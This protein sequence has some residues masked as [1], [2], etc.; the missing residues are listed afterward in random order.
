MFP[1]NY[2]DYRRQGFLPK[3]FPNLTREPNF[4]NERRREVES[5]LI[6]KNRLLEAY[7]GAVLRSEEIFKA[8]LAQYLRDKGSDD[9]SI[10]QTL[11]ELPRDVRRFWTTAFFGLPESAER[12]LKSHLNETGDINVLPPPPNSDKVLDRESEQRVAK[13]YN[14]VVNS[15][16]LDEYLQ[17]HHSEARTL[18]MESD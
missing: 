7:G 5:V 11:K 8:N 4:I 13:G 1:G 15:R 2:E 12:L 16:V 9:E 3:D 10:A 18:E 14:A 6:P 17:E